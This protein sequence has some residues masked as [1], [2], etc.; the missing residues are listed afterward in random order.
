MGTR[1]LK[2]GEKYIHQELKDQKK[3]LDRMKKATTD[4]GKTW[5]G[6]DIPPIAS[7]AQLDKLIELHE[8][9]SKEKF[10][11]LLRSLRNDIIPYNKERKE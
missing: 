8:T 5:N 1:M 10:N 2:Y 6:Y 7:V 11:I 3:F 4:K 9:I